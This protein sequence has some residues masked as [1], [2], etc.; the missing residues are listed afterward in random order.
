MLRLIAMGVPFPLGDPSSA[1]TGWD[2]W[3]VAG[4][5]GCLLLLRYV[6]EVRLQWPLV[7]ACLLLGTILASVVNALGIPA[8][9][10]VA[11]AAAMMARLLLPALH[12]D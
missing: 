1:S 9:L 6:V 3:P 11:M 2:F 5:I 12:L 8:G 7:L 10:G 4:F